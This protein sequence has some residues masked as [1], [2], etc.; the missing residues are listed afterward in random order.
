MMVMWFIR[1]FVF[2]LQESPKYLM[3]CGKDEEAVASAHRVAAINGKTSTL[4]V[5]DLKQVEILAG[6]SSTDGVNVDT[7]ARAAVMRKLSKFDSSH[8]KPLFATPKLAKSTSILIAFWG[9]H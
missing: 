6:M 2:N 7:S 4:T 5:T 3:G 1:F 8:V 9:E